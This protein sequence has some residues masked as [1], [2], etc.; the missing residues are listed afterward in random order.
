MTHCDIMNGYVFDV[1][2]NGKAVCQS[3]QIEF[4]LVYWIQ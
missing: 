1:V 2:K 3:E 4:E